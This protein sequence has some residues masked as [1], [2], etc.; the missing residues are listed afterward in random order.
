MNTV[1]TS[2][3]ILP[4]DNTRWIRRASGLI[5]PMT[6]IEKN[7]DYYLQNYDVIASYVCS[8]EGGHKEF[9]DKNIKK[10]YRCRFCG[11]TEP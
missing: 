8:S 9:V 5:T 7:A 4:S 3:I 2:K 11:K 10:P 6:P 1:D